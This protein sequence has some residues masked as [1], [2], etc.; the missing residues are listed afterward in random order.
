MINT[1]DPTRTAS[2]RLALEAELGLPAKMPLQ[3]S[4]SHEYAW[5]DQ[6]GASVVAARYCGLRRPPSLSVFWQHGVFGPWNQIDPGTIT[7]HAHGIR[8]R[9]LFVA[10]QDEVEFLQRHGVHDVHAI[11][12]PILYAKS[13]QVSRERGSLLVMPQHSLVGWK[14]EDRDVMDRYAAYIASLRPRFSRIVACLHY[15]AFVNGDWITQFE[16]EGIECIEGADIADANALIRM[17]T[18]FERFESVTGNVWGSHVAYALAF[19]ARTSIFGPSMKPRQ[20]DIDADPGTGGEGSSTNRDRQ[21]IEAA[22]QSATAHLVLPPDEGSSD[23]EFGRWLIGSEHVRPPAELLR[24][25]RWTRWHRMK[26]RLAPRRVWRSV[27]W[28]LRRALPTPLCS[29]SSR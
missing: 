24:L 27:R 6:Y 5:S 20:S 11:G 15:A 4:H 28:R 22:L 8:D 3:L 12:M 23:M 10:R 26:A 21:R 17:R 19:G 18:L 16:R 9:R 25:F 2:R 7:Y 13:G 29:A 14:W 1:A